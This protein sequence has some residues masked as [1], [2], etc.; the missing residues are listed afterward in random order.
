LPPRSERTK[1]AL[2][3]A[4]GVV[5]VGAA[6]F[7]LARSWLRVHPRPVQALRM[8]QIA[9]EP[10]GAR[11]FIKGL[12]VG[13]VTPALVP[14]GT[15]SFDVELR[16]DG[17]LTFRDRV[18]PTQVGSELLARLVAAPVERALAQPEPAD[19]E[20]P[21]TGAPARAE[22]KPRRSGPSAATARATP[23]ASREVA[24][25]NNSGQTGR[26]SLRAIGPWLE[27]Y[28]GK[29]KLGITPLDHI[30]VPAGTLKLRLVNTETG[31]ERVITMVVPPQGE[32]HRT[33]TP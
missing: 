14:L 3:I 29:R 26:L 16:R 27:V 11:I 24:G 28:L 32:A 10:P 17:Y 7:P 23:A 19:V 1:W 8:L 15:S 22:P 4:A 21:V 6:S 13:L 20:P 25:D 33:I 30:E 2:V 12:D 5:V 9:S 18:E 31:A